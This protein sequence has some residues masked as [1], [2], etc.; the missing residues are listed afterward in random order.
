MIYLKKNTSNDVVL[1]LNENR[2]IT[3]DTFY[4]FLFTNDQTNVSKI[5]TATNLSSNVNRYDQFTIIESLTEDLTGGTV[6]LDNGTYR[7]SIYE[8]S[9]STLQISACTSVVETGKVL[10]SGTTTSYVYVPTTSATKVAY[11]P[12]N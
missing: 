5:F 3:G 10:V 12:T 6:N 8:A 4:T 9:A 7:Y 11:K 2:T 1:T